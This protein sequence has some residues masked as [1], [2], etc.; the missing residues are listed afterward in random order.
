MKPAATAV[1]GEREK[2]KEK[3]PCDTATINITKTKTE[4]KK[5]SEKEKLNTG[6]DYRLMSGQAS[7]LKT[8]LG[9][10]GGS[11]GGR[12]SPSPKLLYGEEKVEKGKRDFFSLFS[13]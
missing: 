13:Y 4:K 12:H 8:D 1:G 10:G 7:I 5:K 9:H 11:K 6:N 2:E 3:A